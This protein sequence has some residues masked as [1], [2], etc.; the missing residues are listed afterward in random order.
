MQETV[1]TI[2]KYTGLI[3]ASVS[4]MWGITHDFKTKD[5]KGVHIT[6]EGRLAIFF[7]ILGLLISAGST[8]MADRKE[9]QAVIDKATE[10]QLEAIEKSAREQR[11]AAKEQQDAIAE[12][13]RVSTTLRHR[14]FEFRVATALSPNGR[15]PA[16]WAG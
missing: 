10:K 13:R 4:S 2:L 6:K 7:T 1:L 15:R 12:A 8:Y 11:E 9:H 3:M 16:G 5:D 14:P